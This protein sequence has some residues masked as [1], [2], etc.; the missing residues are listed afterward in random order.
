MDLLAI[1]AQATGFFMWPIVEFQNENFVAGILPV[2]VFLT[3]AGWWENYVDRR[4]PLEPIRQ[5]GR[6]KDRLKKTRYYVYTFMSVWKMTLFFSSML[7]F[8]HLT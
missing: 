7:L 3:S 8:L 2:A 5:L 4:S 6:I 1:G